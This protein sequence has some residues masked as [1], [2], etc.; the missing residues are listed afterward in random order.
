MHIPFLLSLSGILLGYFLKRIGLVKGEDSAPLSRIVMNVTLPALILLTLTDAHLKRELIILPL[1]PIVIGILGYG[2]GLF[3]FRKLPPEQ[4]GVL[5]MGTMG[6]NLGLFAY[7]LF[8]GLFG[9][10]GVEVAA[11]LDVGNAV[12]IFGLCYLAGERYAPVQSGEKRGVAGVLKVFLTSVPFMSYVV[13]LVVNLAGLRLPEFLISWL[14]ILSHANQF[15]VL[16][17]LGLVLSFDWRHHLSKGL[18]MLL[19]LR[20]SLALAAGFI[21][22]NILPLDYLIRKIV[23]LSLVLPTGFSIVPFSIDFGYD[24]DSAGAMMNITLIVSFFMM[25]G[26]TILL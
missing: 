10:T 8:R 14:T 7:P 24:R 9:D 3:L 5:L 4:K 6:L 11:L 18:I 2:A 17:V 12:A 21:F 13:S 15:L 22:W 26:L 20:Y 25:W 19:L 16:I 1:I 23:V